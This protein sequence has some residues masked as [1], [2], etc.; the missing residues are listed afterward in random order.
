MP[1]VRGYL[2]D[3]SF[4]P[5]PLVIGV[6]GHHDLRKEDIPALNERLKATF[7]RLEEEYANPPSFL[8]QTRRRI[9]PSAIDQ[10]KEAWRRRPGATPMIVLSSLAEGADQLAAE[11][12]LNRGLRV[13]APLPLPADEYRRDFELRPAALKKFDALIRHPLVQTL[14]VGY[15]NGSSPDEVRSFGEK[16]NLQYRRAG[17]FIARHCD[18]LIALWDG[19]PG[20]GV[21]GTA[22]VVGFKLSG[23][24]LDAVSRLPLLGRAPPRPGSSDAS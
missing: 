16:R 8:E 22:E 10:F 6:T 3:I 9:R 4:E 19:Q 2:V 18:V 21:G 20:T 23:I 15:E 24:P 12:A 7:E 13:I 17:A 5:L 14:F 11:V 1:G